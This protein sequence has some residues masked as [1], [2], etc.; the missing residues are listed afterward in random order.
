MPLLAFFLDN[1]PTTLFEDVCFFVED[2]A[3]E[4]LELQMGGALE[5][6]VNG[7]LEGGIDDASVFDS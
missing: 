4:E 1:V 6:K 2:E 5:V 7:L 3:E